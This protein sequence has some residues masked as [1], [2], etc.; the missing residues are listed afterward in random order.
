MSW[1]TGNQPKN[2]DKEDINRLLLDKGFL[3]EK[4]A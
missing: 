1:E 3:E 4:E 2:I